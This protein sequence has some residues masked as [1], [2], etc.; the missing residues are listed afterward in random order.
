MQ[1]SG[2]KIGKIVGLLMLYAKHGQMTNAPNHIKDL[3]C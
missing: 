1:R 3:S 2:E